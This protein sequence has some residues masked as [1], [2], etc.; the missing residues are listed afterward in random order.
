VEAVDIGR[1]RESTEGREG[2]RIK[3]PYLLARPSNVF[4]Q[5]QLLVNYANRSICFIN[6]I[7]LYRF[8]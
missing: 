7:V 6:I 2:G 4:D 8:P 5:Q 3:A 1:E